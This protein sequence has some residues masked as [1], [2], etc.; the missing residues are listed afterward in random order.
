MLGETISAPEAYGYSLAQP[1]VSACLSAP[2]T[3]E[4]LEQNLTVLRAPPL[5][6]PRQAELR[7]HGKTV[8]QESRDFAR[9]IRRHPIGLADTN[10]RDLVKWLDQ[11]DVLDPR[12]E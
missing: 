12:F 10:A 6:Q 3:S 7:A 5:S 1:G 11:E 8:R 9:S 2:R 4:E